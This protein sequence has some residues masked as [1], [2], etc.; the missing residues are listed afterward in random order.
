LRR[1]LHTS[2]SDPA[3]QWTAARKGRAFFA[4]SANYLIDTDYSVI[5]DVEA[6]PTLSAT[7]SAM[8]QLDPAI[9]AETAT[10]ESRYLRIIS[11][12]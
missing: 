8:T 4:Y 2:H 12:P 11:P 1:V 3:S 5:V 6:N 10:A 7:S 9:T